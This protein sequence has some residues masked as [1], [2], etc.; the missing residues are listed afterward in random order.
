[1]DMKISA[2]YLGLTPYLEA[3]QLQARVGQKV[4]GEENLGAHIIGCEHPIVLTKGRRLHGQTLE[5]LPFV[6]DQVDA[7]RGGELALHSPGQLMI[8][9]VTDLNKLNLSVQAW[10]QGLHL[11]TQD[12]FKHLG[13]ETH[14]Q[15]EAGL[16][17]VAGKIM[18]MG[19]R[20][21]SGLSTH[22]LAINVN[23]DL[24][25][26][27]HFSACGTHKARVDHLATPLNLEELFQ[28]WCRFF[29]LRYQA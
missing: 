8:Y 16:W 19:L 23:N 22:G 9:P 6:A 21:Q 1:M 26:Y 10:T 3:T 25:Y 11:V 27:A 12:F 14:L 18:F 15:P 7:D 4:M 20:I 28:L 2:Q 13:V 5:A 29:K 17:T 24:S